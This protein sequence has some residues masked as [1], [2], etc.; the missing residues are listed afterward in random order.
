MFLRLS[1]ESETGPETQKSETAETLKS[2]AARALKSG[3]ANVSETQRE[4]WDWTNSCYSPA[5]PTGSVN[6]S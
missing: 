1:V 2:G 6:Y 3:T 5:W 4:V